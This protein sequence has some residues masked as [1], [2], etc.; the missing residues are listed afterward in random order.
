MRN[1]QP[2]REMYVDLE[3]DPRKRLRDRCS[4]IP[5][6]RGPWKRLLAHSCPGVRRET[7]SV[8]LSGVHKLPEHRS[9]VSLREA[10]R[11][12]ARYLK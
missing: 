8:G 2:R 6:Q 3:A 7:G 10:R 9:D 1:E 11:L 4:R 5:E 12:R